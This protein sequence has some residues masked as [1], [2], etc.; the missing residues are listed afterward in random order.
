MKHFGLVLVATATCMI[1]ACAGAYQMSENARGIKSRM[2]EVQASAAVAQAMSPSSHARGL[3]QSGKLELR[4]G[5]L[6]RM[7]G[8]MFFYDAYEAYDFHISRSGSQQKTTYRLRQITAQIDLRTVKKAYVMQMPTIHCDGVKVG[9]VVTFQAKD[10]GRYHSVH[11]TDSDFDKFI[12]A[13]SVLAP[14]INFLAGESY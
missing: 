3:C 2:T 8:P 1:T 14:D 5:L 11:V 13:L 10:T 4:A 6:S 9:R 7:E 12:A